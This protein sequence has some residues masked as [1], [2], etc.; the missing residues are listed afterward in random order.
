MNYGLFKNKKCVFPEGINDNRNEEVYEPFAR[1]ALAIIM[2]K[3]I[4]YGETG[5]YGN[6]VSIDIYPLTGKEVLCF[7]MRSS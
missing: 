2:F 1:R 7:L 5:D 3:L 4:P 6:V